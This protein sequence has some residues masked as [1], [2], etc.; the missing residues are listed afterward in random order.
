[1]IARLYAFVLWFL[2]G[3]IV[4]ISIS[5]FSA[6]FIPLPSGLKLQ[7]DNPQGIW[8][9]FPSSDFGEVHRAFRTR[10]ALATHWQ[11][12]R[13]LQIPTPPSSL[14]PQHVLNRMEFGFPFRC[15]FSQASWLHTALS[16]AEPKLHQGILLTWRPEWIMIQ[17]TLYTSQLPL[18]PIWR[19]LLLNTTSFGLVSFLCW[20][21][22]VHARA[23][24]RLRRGHCSQCG[25]DLQS[26]SMCPECG[27]LLKETI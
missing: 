10:H 5:W 16:T 6:I 8:H 12:Q 15:L 20:R 2:I 24:L 22:Y 23:V 7:R 3:L 13:D 1:M 18:A 9:D 4:T 14:P 27:L 11:L 26:L 19:G 21:G 17:N 25:Y